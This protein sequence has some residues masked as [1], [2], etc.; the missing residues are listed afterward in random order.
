MTQSYDGN[1]SGLEMKTALPRN[2]FFAAIVIGAGI[3]AWWF[4]MRSSPA[5]TTI[6]VA[7]KSDNS[8]IVA[9]LIDNLHGIYSAKF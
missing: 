2:K 4:W 8:R 5:S 1:S 6:A 9:E 3:A 7:T